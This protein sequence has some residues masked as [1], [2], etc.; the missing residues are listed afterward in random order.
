MLFRL[1][2]V[3]CLFTLISC[4]HTGDRGN[5]EGMDHTYYESPSSL[6]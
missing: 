2:S 6:R 3:V 1:L 5:N 4:A